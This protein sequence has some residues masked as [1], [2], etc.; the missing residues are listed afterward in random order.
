MSLFFQAVACVVIGLV[1]SV[2]LN[3]QGS[4]SGLLLCLTVCILVI[5]AAIRY[6]QPVMEL[7][8]QL[9]ETASLELDMLTV[10][11]KSVG[12][13]L[14]AEVTVLLCAD[15]GNSAM[16]RAVEILASAVILWLSVPLLTAL[17]ELV[18]SVTEEL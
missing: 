6:L 15:G 17:L 3:R 9:Q 11:L 10:I 5:V 8:G 14:I 12:I 16:G 4:F 13:G 2:L 18:Q 1:L 7:I